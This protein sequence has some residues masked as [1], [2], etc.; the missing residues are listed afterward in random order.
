VT[1]IVPK[2]GLVEASFW[3]FDPTWP[4]YLLGWCKNCFN[5]PLLTNYSK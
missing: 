4:P 3:A 2:G 5:F 1:L